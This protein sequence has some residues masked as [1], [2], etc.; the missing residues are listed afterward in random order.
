MVVPSP[1]LT[2]VLALTSTD[3]ESPVF[4]ALKKE[5]ESTLTLSVL[6]V[7]AVIVGIV[8][9]L[10]VLLQELPA[11]EVH[12]TVPK[13]LQSDPVLGSIRRAAT[14]V[15]LDTATP[16]NFRTMEFTVTS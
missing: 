5:D 4:A 16:W 11:P 9:K 7:P 1:Q 6:E 15:P 14:E 10:N 12:V 8:V 13:P 2:S 3:I